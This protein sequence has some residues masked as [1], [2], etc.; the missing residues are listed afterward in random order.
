MICSDLFLR[1]KR[2][3]EIGIDANIFEFKLF[4]A[5]MSHS[6]ASLD[7]LADSKIST[8]KIEYSTHRLL[9]KVLLRLASD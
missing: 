7:A 3:E 6:A 9:S 8:A 1:R 4:S 2:E 5:R